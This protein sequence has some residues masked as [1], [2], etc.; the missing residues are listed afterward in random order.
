LIQIKCFEQLAL[1]NLGLGIWVWEFG[2]G[3][4]GSGIED[5]EIGDLGL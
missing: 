1:E 3:N 5:W 4:L 2:I